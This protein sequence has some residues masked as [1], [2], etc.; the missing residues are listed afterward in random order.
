MARARK[1]KWLASVHILYDGKHRL[2]DRNTH[3]YKKI[4]SENSEKFILHLC[5]GERKQKE[6]EQRMLVIFWNISVRIMYSI[7]T[8]H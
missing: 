3:T 6:F 5:C 7:S 1:S 8:N 2:A 4:R